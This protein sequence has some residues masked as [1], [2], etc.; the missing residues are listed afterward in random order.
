MKQLIASTALALFLGSAAFADGLTARVNS[1]QVAMGDQF[2]LVLSSGGDGSQPDLAPLYKDFDVLG[3]SQ[4]MQTQIVNGH[5]SQS[6]TWIVTLSPKTTGTLTIPAITAGAVSSDPLTI[7]ALEASQMPKA[8]GAG[9]ISVQASLAGG[10]HYMFQEIPLTVRIETTQPLNRAELIAPSGDFDLTQS[11]P[12]KTSQ[13]SHGGQAINV[14]ERS[15]MLRPQSEGALTIPPFTLRGTVPDPNG[16]RDP[17][18]RGFGGGDPFAR[19]DQM[20]AQMGMPRMNSPFDDMF[21]SG[22]RFTVRSDVLR[23]DVLANPAGAGGWF[24]PAK[25]VELQAEWQPANPVFREGEAVTRRISL[26]ALGARAE[27]L[28]DLTFQD[29][30]GARIYLDDTATNM[31]NTPEGTAARRD[32]VVSVV[33]TQG[34]PVTLPK[35]MVGWFDTAANEARVAT[36]PAVTIDVDGT[37]PAVVSEPPAA[38]DSVVTSQN[39]PARDTAAGL[40]RWG[41]GGGIGAVIGFA[42]LAFWWRRKFGVKSVMSKPKKATPLQALKQAAQSGDQMAFYQALL[43]LDITTRGHPAVTDAITTC[44]AANFAKTAGAAPDLDALYARVAF[45]VGRKM[46]QK[47]PALPGLYPK[48]A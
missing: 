21:A 22:Q 6:V 37:A 4:S 15:Y 29:A 36:L 30:T 48:M 19:M 16:R 45:A 7:T 17:F 35:V 26:L 20:M 8:Q 47:H 13:I 11:G 42:M 10:V 12:D 3:T 1:P 14:I 32:F 34:G 44:E 25:A 23:L 28:P 43:A 18:G 5:R 38:S 46:Q 31:V 39:G 27:Q 41:I 33:P 9:G 24:L 40:P 2:Q